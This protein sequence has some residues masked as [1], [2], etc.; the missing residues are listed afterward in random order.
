MN[1][2]HEALQRQLQCMQTQVDQLQ[3]QLQ[4]KRVRRRP[5]LAVL[6]IA[7]LGL[8]F[9]W[10]AHSQSDSTEF[11]LMKQVAELETRMGN[12]EK[13]LA[14]GKV[15][16]PFS[17]V[18]A[19]GLPIMSVFAGSNRGVQVIND[20]TKPGSTATAVSIE[21]GDVAGVRVRAGN[22]QAWIGGLDKGVGI[23]V[24]GD[25]GVQDIRTLM[26]A[27]LG[28]EVRR[29][30][31]RMS[32]LGVTEKGN[33]A[34]RLYSPEPT[35]ETETRRQLVAVGVTAKDDLGGLE[36]RDSAG[37]LLTRVSSVGNKTGIV[38]VYPASDNASAS[39]Q[40][41]DGGAGLLAVLADD[42]TAI[43]SLS[44]GK[45]GGLFQLTD[46]P[47]DVMVKAGVTD[48]HT[49]GVFAGPESSAAGSFLVGRNPAHPGDAAG[50]D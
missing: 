47:G 16:A 3:Q 1:A 10:A 15:R 39:M 38:S 6:G 30:D 9:S 2:E 23:Y 50:G 40:I 29:S 17:V 48:K 41:N 33:V 19:K 7:A 44:R 18:D 32:T 27:N 14:S 37:K 46:F 21:A 20:A 4:R 36:V 26:T 42:G 24:A 5:F 49:G 22:E 8:I 25:G 11:L 45:N 13:Q 28:F 35:P 34:L 31:Q 43:A 12:I